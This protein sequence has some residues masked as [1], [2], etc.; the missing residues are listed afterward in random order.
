MFVSSL[1]QTHGHHNYDQL[2]HHGLYSDSSRLTS[3]CHCSPFLHHACAL[4]FYDHAIII[5]TIFTT[6]M[7]P[8]LSLTLPSLSLD[9]HSFDYSF[10]SHLCSFMLSLPH[11][12]CNHSIFTYDGISSELPFS[13]GHSSIYSVVAVHCSS[14]A[15]IS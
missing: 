12:L 10:L 6:H 4:L 3:A 5:L 13:H 8:Y 14:L 9:L 11:F 1:V 15:L 7:F 2:C